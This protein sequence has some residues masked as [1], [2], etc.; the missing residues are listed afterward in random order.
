MLLRSG[1]YSEKNNWVE[2]ATGVG[3]G[4]YYVMQLDSL[5][6]GIESHP[7]A[8]AGL[9]G[10]IIVLSIVLSIISSILF[11]MLTG[12]SSELEDERDILIRRKSSVWSN[13]GLH[14]GI[15]ILMV[16][17]VINAALNIES[18]N[19]FALFANLPL[20]DLLFHGLVIL[21][22]LSQV[23]QNSFEIFLQRRGF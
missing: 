14:I 21:S 19:D 7:Y 15:G 18:N 1:S 4:I 2:L 12:N 5:Q 16:Q 17:V 20:I 10:K 11:G 13:L 8:I 9:M 6:G 3:V 23:M 22:I